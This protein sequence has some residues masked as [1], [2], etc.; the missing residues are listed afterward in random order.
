MASK[1]V[2]IS[3]VALKAGVSV[4][5]VSKVLNGRKGVSVATRERVQRMLEE[6]GYQRLPRSD[7]GSRLVDFVITGLDS[8]WSMVLLRG[9][10]AEAARLGYDVVVTTTEGRPLGATDWLD[11]VMERGSTGVVVVI[12]EVLPVIRD[13]LSQLQLPVVL[14]DPVGTG[15]HAWTT[16]AATDW[17]GARD[18]TDHLIGL[19]HRRIGM[20]TGP[21]GQACHQDRLDGYRAALS[22]AGIGYDE[23]LVRHGDSLVSGGVRFGTELL[24]GDDAPTAII[25]GSDEQAYGIYLAAG[26]LGIRIPDDLSVVGFDDVDLCQWV[27]PPLTTVH[28][29]LDDM[30][31]AATRL[32]VELAQGDE[33]MRRNISL[34]TSLVVRESTA[35]PRG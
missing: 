24:Q 7:R 23:S 17:A 5:T 15:D 27:T 25:S 12:S 31:R 20:I 16:V 8:Q 11:R 19:G 18:A 13:A 10:Q 28:Q 34:A 1:A 2:T 32:V 3:D 6:Q 33:S 21:I 30:A 14:V 22:R 4:P 35:A 26:E 29:P 9:A